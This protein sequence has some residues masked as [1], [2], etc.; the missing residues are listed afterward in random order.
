MSTH[1]YKYTL[2]D[3]MELTLCV[4]EERQTEIGFKR[5]RHLLQSQKP[6]KNENRVLTFFIFKKRSLKGDNV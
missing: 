4:S 3:M 5:H 2:R 1:V 6:P